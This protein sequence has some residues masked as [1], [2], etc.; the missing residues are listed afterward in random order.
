MASSG[1][2]VFEPWYDG[3]HST[4]L[5]YLVRYRQQHPSGEP[6]ILVLSD[7]YRERH[8][9]LL[10]L[11]DGTAVQVKLMS[12]AETE[13]LESLKERYYQARS[14]DPA[15]I[16]PL[17]AYEVE[18][19][20]QYTSQLSPRRGLLMYLCIQRM[21]A[22]LETQL[23]CQFDGIFFNPT[24]HYGGCGLGDGS[25]TL[26]QV[27]EKFVLSRFLKHPR[28]RR[29]H[30][31]DSYAVAAAR[32]KMG[33]DKITY[34]ADPVEQLGEQTAEAGRCL[35]KQLG[36]KTGRRA[37][38]L[39]GALT[40]RKGIPQLLDSLEQLPPESH[41]RLC[42][43]LV[44]QPD[45]AEAEHYRQRLQA[46]QQRRPIQIISRFEFVPEET[47][48]AYFAAADV[49]L[50]PYPRHVGM[51]GI[52]LWAAAAGRP[53][54][55]SEFGLMGRLTRK[56]SLGITVDAR[57]PQAI[58][59]GIEACLEQPAED[60]F[61]QAQARQLIRQHSHENFCFSLLNDLITDNVHS[62][63]S[64]EAV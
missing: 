7:R 13:R 47:V 54:L 62:L 10:A 30:C 36:V 57:D 60:L 32:K 28:L 38:L 64:H 23:P 40:R 37:F 18:L 43:L 63:T 53:L 3:H 39:F 20:R 50:A 24:F 44:G 48:A 14:G 9:D 15:A 46:L 29:L 2:M 55:G 21:A 12:P 41:R 4:Y 17:L 22:L 34:L 33:S 45:P 61:N 49:V 1:L 56:H 35:R 11:A 8:G 19:F 27:K 51:S 5:R 16:P 59:Q 6:L 25:S 52:V 58:A 42:L 26:K 31:L